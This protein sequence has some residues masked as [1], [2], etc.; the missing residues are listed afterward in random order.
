MSGKNF[1][2]VRLQVDSQVFDVGWLVSDFLI[3][4]SLALLEVLV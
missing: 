1:K 2:S 3:V 4:D